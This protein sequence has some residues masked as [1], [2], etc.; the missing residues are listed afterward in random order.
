M[1]RLNSNALGAAGI[2]AAFLC[3]A[4]TAWALDTHKDD[5]ASAACVE[6]T[7]TRSTAEE[8]S[9]EETIEELAERVFDRAAAQFKLLDAK[10]N[11]SHRQ[12]RP[13]DDSEPAKATR[14]TKS[15]RAAKATRQTQ[16][17]FPRSLNADGSLMT[18]DIMWWCSGFYPG[19]LWLV[20]EYTGDENFKHLA[21]K[22]T[23]QLEPLRYRENDHDV[24]FQ[25]MCSYGN[26]LRLTGD[27]E[28]EAVIKDAAASLSTRFNP[29]VGC[30][31]S[32]DG[33]TWA[34]PVIIDNMMN[35]ELM[36]KGAE[37]SGDTT[38]AD[39]AV[40][41]AE[42]TIKNHFRPDYSTWHLVNYDPEDGQVLGKQTV[43]GFSDDSAWSRGQAWALYG[44]TMVY[45]FTKDS[46]FLDQ[47]LKVAEYLL[48][49]LP[50][51]GI[52][53]WDYDSDEIPNDLR[54]A[55]AAAIMASA[56]VELSR[57]TTDAETAARYQTVARKIITTL[58][59]EEYLAEGGEISGFLLKHSVGNKPGNSEVDVPLTYADYYFLEA[60]L[61]LLALGK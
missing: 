38:L 59:S 31:K 49:R 29:A 58:A 25:I 28:Y 56:L 41:H 60:I 45:R 54:D 13:A 16:A 14:E 12:N 42:T 61:R 57:Y 11:A 32:W 5:G 44:Y 8:I 34:Y 4:S 17:V 55:S 19:S 33:N 9:T 27:K 30:I 26:A 23:L 3:C 36:F 43:Q 2:V 47:A 51:D 22:Y 40:T 52:P 18:S 10:L 21:L 48:P 35:L 24:G 37:L 20:Y 6:K 15:A 1:T 39:K 50:E 7:Q 53:Y 46:K